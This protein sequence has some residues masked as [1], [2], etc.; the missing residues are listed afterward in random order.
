VEGVGASPDNKLF[1]RPA[2]PGVY[3]LASSSERD[4]VASHFLPP[5]FSGSCTVTCTMPLHAAGTPNHRVGAR[6]SSEERL[7]D[8]GTHVHDFRRCL[9]FHA[10]G[11]RP[12]R[13]ACQE[14]TTFEWLGDRA[15]VSPVGFGLLCSAPIQ[16]NASI[17]SAAT[18]GYTH[19]GGLIQA[20]EETH[21]I[22]AHSEAELTGKVAHAQPSERISA[23][24]RD[25]TLTSCTPAADPFPA[26]ERAD[27]PIQQFP[28]FIRESWIRRRM[29]T[30]RH[31]YAPDV[32]DD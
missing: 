9:L 29:S 5:H 32:L 22:G 17:E 3:E 14:P 20:A 2:L 16:S 21:A 15:R 8:S 25:F 26:D 30:S 27:A 7:H 13:F 12:C 23:C 11:P 31:L 10:V 6:R 24:G 19:T 18:N 28:N 4:H 1:R